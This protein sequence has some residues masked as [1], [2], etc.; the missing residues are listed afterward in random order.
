MCGNYWFLRGGSVLF[1]RYDNINDIFAFPYT[2][3]Y[4]YSHIELPKLIIN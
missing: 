3:I 2:L 1:T 4:N